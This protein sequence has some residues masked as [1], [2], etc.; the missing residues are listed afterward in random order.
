MESNEIFESCSWK[1]Y[2]VNGIKGWI[3]NRNYIILFPERTGYC[4]LQQEGMPPIML[5]PGDIFAIYK[6]L[7]EDNYL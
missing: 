6:K 1:P 2:E 5:L 3:N 4:Y 7:E